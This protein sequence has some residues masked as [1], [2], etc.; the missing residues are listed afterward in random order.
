MNDNSDKKRTIIEE[1][2]GFK[3]ALSSSCPIDVR[4]RIEGEIEAPSMAVSQT[5][6]VHGRAK[7]GVVHSDGELSGEFDAEQLVLAGVVKDN[8]IIRARSLEV[9]LSASRGKLQVVFGECELAVGDE[10]SENDMLDAQDA[11]AK[12]TVAPEPSFL[13]PMAEPATPPAAEAAD[14]IAEAARRASETA[15]SELDGGKK[16]KKKNGAD[17]SMKT[18]W[19]EPPPPA[20]G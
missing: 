15:A 7:V 12:P 11:D 3:G 16:K 1:G 20:G 18:G 6:S 13:A 4:G 5:G 17:E 14:D 19:S 9:K 8:T 10:P 2:T